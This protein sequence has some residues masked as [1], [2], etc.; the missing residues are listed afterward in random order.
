MMESN[1]FNNW[2]SKRFIY[3]GIFVFLIV[4]IL[5]WIRLQTPVHQSAPGRKFD[6]VS[7]DKTLI[8]TWEI[9]KNKKLGIE[10][11]YPQQVEGNGCNPIFV[12]GENKI[13]V[14]RN[15][16]ILME[17]LHGLSF[18][19]YI[20]SKKLFLEGQPDLKQEQLLIG[21]EKAIQFSYYTKSEGRIA[22]DAYIEYFGKVY[23]LHYLS[24]GTCSQDLG[25]NEGD[26]YDEIL[27]NFQFVL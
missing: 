11:Q 21:G 26:L 6:Q 27:K 23:G 5:L 24:I 15:T 13:R 19:D 2:K 18:E 3:V 8:K 10:F 25:N 20:M 4:G 1:F 9:Y 14:G 12:S 17:D 22:R 7:F 16:V